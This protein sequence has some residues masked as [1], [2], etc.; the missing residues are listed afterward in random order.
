MSDLFDTILEEKKKKDLFDQ[1][2]TQPDL[3]DQI[4]TELPNTPNGQ[5][6]YPPTSTAQEIIKG[7]PGVAKETLKEAAIDV[8]AAAAYEGAGLVKGAT[9]G[10]VDPTS[11]LE[12]TPL[13]N[14]DISKKIAEGTGQFI[15]AVAPISK[16]SQG[17]GLGLKSTQ[18][19]AGVRPVLQG[20]I[21]AGITG[22][23]YGAARATDPEQAQ[24]GQAAARAHNALNDA[25]SFIV[26]TGAGQLVDEAAQAFGLGKTNAYNSLRN[27]IIDRFTK[28]GASP[29][30]AAQMADYGLNEAINKGGGWS[31]VTAKDLRDARRAVRKGQTIVLNEGVPPE[32][33]P[34]TSA[35][36]TPSPDLTQEGAAG[37]TL[38]PQALLAG[39]AAERVPVTKPTLFKIADENNVPSGTI[40]PTENAG[41]PKIRIDE[42]TVSPEGIKYLQNKFP[43]VSQMIVGQEF[44]LTQEQMHTTLLKSTAA[45]EETLLRGGNQQDANSAAAKAFAETAKPF[46]D[47]NRTVASKSEETAPGTKSDVFDEA[48]KELA[49]QPQPTNQDL[50]G[51]VQTM[52]LKP[53]E[54]TPNQYSEAY[55]GNRTFPDVQAE[56]RNLVKEAIK[57]GQSIPEPVRMQYPELH[58]E[59]NKDAARA[60]A[61]QILASNKID[62]Q[63]VVNL[64]DHIVADN[65]AF[66]VG[67]NQD[68]DPT[69]HIIRGET[70]TP[71]DP[72]SGERLQTVI[73]LANGA[74]S[75]TGHHEAFHAVSNILLDDAE[76]KLLNDKFGGVEN[77]ADAFADY[78]AGKAPAHETAIRKIFEK[79]KQF[80]ERLKNYFAHKKFSTAEDIFDAID[81]GDLAGRATK[82]AGDPEYSVLDVF[83]RKQAPAFVKTPEFSKWFGDS[84]IVDEGGKPLTVYHGTTANF[85]EFDPAKRE[86]GFHFARNPQLAN[87]RLDIY[88]GRDLE[89]Y[90]FKSDFKPG[91]R[92]LP[93]YLKMKKPLHID[94]DIDNWDVVG[95][96]QYELGP[97]NRGIFTEKQ[98]QAW[99]NPEDVRQ[100][101]KQE[102][103]DGII[104]RNQY[105]N[106]RGMSD[107]DRQSYIVFEPNQIKSATGNVGTFS[108]ETPDI[109]YSSEEKPEA[110]FIG[111]QES[112]RGAVPLYNV[113]SIDGKGIDTLYGTDTLNKRNIQVPQTPTL[114]QWKANKAQY[115]MEERK[116]AEPFYSQLQK[117]VEAKLPN[118]ASP[119]QLKNILNSQ[120]VKKE[121]VEW[122]GINEWL[123][124]Q[125]GPVSKEKV[126][127][128]LKDNNL[129]IQE[130]T[131]GDN[132]MSQAYKQRA[133]EMAR[134]YGRQS[135]LIA[136]TMGRL[137]NRSQRDFGFSQ[138]DAANLPWRLME[139][140]IKPEELPKGLQVDANKY[141]E[142]RVLFKEAETNKETYPIK[143]SDTKFSKYTLPG[144]ENYREMLFTLPPKPKDVRVTY[145]EYAN[146]YKVF[147]PN[148]SRDEI[149]KAYDKFLVQAVKGESPGGSGIFNSSHFSEPNVLA[150]VRLNDRVDADGKKTLFLE[151]IQSDWHQ[152]GR[153]EGYASE[154]K[155]ITQEEINTANE[156]I[157]EIN[158]EIKRI[159]AK[160]DKSDSDENERV[161][162]KNKYN[163][164]IDERE[165]IRETITKHPEVGVPDAPFKKSWHEFVLKRMLRYA[166][167]NGYDSISWTTG[168]QQ[169]ERYDLSKQLDSITYEKLQNGNFYVSAYDKNG[170]EIVR[171]TGA[172][173]DRISE[174]LGKEMAEKIQSGAGEDYTLPHASVKKGIK[175]LSGLDLKI[176]GS[177][178]KG[179]YDKI[180]PEFLNKYTK[181]WGG[182]VGE[183]VL[184]DLV[185]NEEGQLKQKSSNEPVRADMGM[186]PV[187]V[188]SLDITPAMKESVLYQGQPQ[189]KAEEVK[190]VEDIPGF[191]TPE[192]SFE[193]SKWERFKTQMYDRFQPIKYSKGKEIAPEFK[194]AGGMY[195]RSYVLARTLNG[196]IRGISEGVLHDLNER[197]KP[198]KSYEDRQLLNKIYSLRNL[199]D[200][201]R[202]GK[203]TSGITAKDAT[204]QLDAMKKDLGI[205]RFNRIAKVAD[206]LADIQN[207]KGLD[208]LVQ[209]KVISK[210]QA[211]IL[212]ERY[213]NY[214][215]SEIMDEILAS[216]QPQF[217]RADNGE[218]LGKINKSFLKTKEGTVMK[219]NDDVID[220]IRRSLVTKVAAAQ[221]QTVVDQIA[222]DFGRQIGN[223]SFREGQLVSEINPTKIPPGYT[224]S[225]IKASGGRIFAV[226]K[227]VAD[228]L[229]GLN[230]K[231]A[232]F[233][234]QAMSSYNRLFRAGATTLR[235][236]FVFNNVFRDTQEALF[237]ARSVPGQNSQL[238]S[239]VKGA[240]HA[241]QESL[242]I[243]DKVYEAWS[244]AGA[245][246][247]GMVSSIPKNVEVPF[248]LQP[249]KE[250]IKLAM[251]SIVSLPFETIAKLAE[252]SESTSRLAEWLRLEG[253]KLNPELKALQARDITVDFE[254]VGDA[255][256]RIN[257][258]VPF[259]NANVQGTVNSFRAFKDQPWVSIAKMGAYVILPAVLLYEYNKRFKN[260]EDV[261]PYIKSNYWYVNTGIKVNQD[262]KD[263][264]VLVT[265]RKGEFSQQISYYVDALLEYANKDPNFRQR[266]KDFSLQGT[267]DTIVST[268]VPPVARVPIEEA[269]NRNFFTSRPIITPSIEQVD[270]AHQ[271]KPGTTDTA[272]RL[273]EL[274]GAS[275]ARM[276][277]IA[278][279]MFPASQQVLEL[280]D[281]LF[282][283]Q[284][285]VKR[286]NIKV[287]P[288]QSYIPVVRTPSGFFNQQESI[289]YDYE[290][291]AKE[292]ARTKS[293]LFEQSYRQYLDNKTADNLSKLNKHSQDLDATAR[294]RIIKKVNKQEAEKSLPS[295]VKAVYNLPKK[296]RSKFL[297]E[298]PKP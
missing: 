169:A 168:E 70:R 91:S 228:L 65:E 45:G 135:A 164:L 73:N 32:V 180:I 233:I 220:I 280:S 198:L 291:K 270:S 171:E 203:T 275:P 294:E 112:S 243:P 142:Q 273:G 202:V 158:K 252:F 191:N 287:F 210:Q 63:S 29:E 193:P 212:R 83:R 200:L 247:G 77:S 154:K 152:K 285:E 47:E 35:G 107:Q 62:D 201:D 4:S 146:D 58:N 218:P 261:D 188:N 25:A 209:G 13:A 298:N 278:T 197:L 57:S 15:G 211:D 204:D 156:K 99:K 182:R 288:V 40:P 34:E 138:L 217:R 52:G 69:K 1:V 126:L 194:Q 74:T 98:V 24:E 190:K 264:P 136:E 60:A 87:N 277:H 269:A 255:M 27:D 150:H 281:T 222:E 119:E 283:P 187:K 102:G 145:D 125:K 88:S 143:E 127:E 248:R 162:L 153:R 159:A 176:G 174:V 96:L 229:D 5:T 113:P 199:A 92:V 225:S 2:E 296:L 205:E 223:T 181:K 208:I 132:T 76:K 232:D 279:G 67:Y 170:H 81:K 105:E 240:F 33:P 236:P 139:G 206:D 9:L 123:A 39:P 72:I 3:F 207:K 7:I 86:L 104:Y 46:V 109:R 22:S 189:Y 241:M 38:T 140:K 286:K 175:R 37:P 66:K 293:F 56:H 6:I 231:Q 130:V 148:A 266:L 214:L 167:E 93:V 267:L 251:E 292:E 268:L 172:T 51:V 28:K 163:R 116:P 115:K 110:K 151:E 215:R 253:S 12:K 11:L 249:P 124:E 237:K 89:D 16:I 276:E 259:L 61:Q 238:A 230:Q 179:F 44:H 85:A 134:E 265:I 250:K 195:T 30:Q 157:D 242:G 297:Q 213:P 221:K 31:D 42:K 260:D 84:K 114:E 90:G 282:K 48:Q 128:F 53:H 121:E 118:S 129:Q 274:T 8:P 97:S 100:A 144:G 23:I 192:G 80:L 166:S 64:V 94:H 106:A 186:S 20:L 141:L 41:I 165:G 68:Y 263:L 147:H 43:A 295:D 245:A 59:V 160:M 271:F 149:N 122:S 226:R 258:V 244:H 246:Y 161:I 239:Y 49:T 262:G 178:M 78:K 21:Q 183:S 256:K 36:A 289:S 177:G 79:I 185:S 111:Y 26:L 227:D 272:R 19:L 254:K 14:A 95:E 257:Q 290:K 133:D 82:P 17:V 235:V 54:L 18:L 10:Y 173:P 50:Q 131:K 184:G 224:K 103:Y 196:K 284:P 108:S 219:I 155:S 117:V 75:S 216:D 101:L 55:G 137:T 234:T 120:D 71:I